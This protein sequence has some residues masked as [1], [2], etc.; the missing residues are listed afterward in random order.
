MKEPIY[1]HPGH[2]PGTNKFLQKL[3]VW[4]VPFVVWSK[5]GRRGFIFRSRA[6]DWYYFVSRE[7]THTAVASI[8]RKGWFRGEE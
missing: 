8:A 4:I 6:L 3:W 7:L 5:E 1:L 2:R